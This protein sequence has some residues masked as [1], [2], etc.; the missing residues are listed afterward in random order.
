LVEVGD[1]ATVADL[2]PIE[3][4]VI[5]TDP[6]HP[7]AS[8]F[9]PAAL[10]AANEAAAGTEEEAIAE[11]APDAEAEAVAEGEAKPEEKKS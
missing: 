6:S 11:A 8:V 9:E 1:H 3:G 10:Q 4:V 5:K 2:I 7:L